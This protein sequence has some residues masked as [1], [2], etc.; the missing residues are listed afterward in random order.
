MNEFY[1]E[2]FEKAKG[3]KNDFTSKRNKRQVEII[4]EIKNKYPDIKGSELKEK[5]KK[6][7]D[8]EYPEPKYLTDV[9]TFDFDLRKDFLKKHV[10]KSKTYEEGNIMKGRSDLKKKGDKYEVETELNVRK[11]LEPKVK[12][13]LKKSVNEELERGFKG[14]SINLDYDDSSSSDEEEEKPKPKV[15]VKELKNYA[16]M[17]SHLLEHIEDPKEKPDK[18]DY[19]DAKRL[20]NN[21]EVVKKKRGRPRKGSGIDESKVLRPPTT[22]NPDGTRFKKF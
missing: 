12:R 2:E 6:I 15:D 7:I 16:R 1:E 10:K 3:I 13:A 4:K 9:Y 19:K 5:V 11:G 21:M 22:T 18:K 14:G 20:I 17:L 8:K